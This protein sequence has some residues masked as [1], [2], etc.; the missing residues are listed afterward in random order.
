MRVEVQLPKTSFQA[1]E[2][3]EVQAHL[4]NE[5]NK[6][7]KVATA[8]LVQNYHIR[9]QGIQFKSQA[10]LKGAKSTTPIE[11]KTSADIKLTFEV[12]RDV[13][14][15]FEANLFEVSHTVGTQLCGSPSREGL[16]GNKDSTE[17]MS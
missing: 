7:M 11:K 1:G 5:S 15:S 2:V 17:T 12:P 13:I 3:I 8:T 4:D 9:A 16:A 10:S 6:T 14:P